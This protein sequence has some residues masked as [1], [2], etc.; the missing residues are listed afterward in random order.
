MQGHPVK[1]VII[2][3]K[4]FLK[5]LYYSESSLSTSFFLKKLSS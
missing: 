3:L 1:E 4:Y 2:P 5:I